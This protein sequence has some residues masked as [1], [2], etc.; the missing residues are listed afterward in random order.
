MY[1][2]KVISLSFLLLLPLIAHA[3]VDRQDWS[4]SKEKSI[5]LSESGNFKKSPDHYQS[6]EI[7]IDRFSSKLQEKS[8]EIEVPDPDGNFQTFVINPS[9]V[10]APEVAHLYTIKT[11][12]GYAKANPSIKIACDISQNGFNAAIFAVGKTYFVTPTNNVK[13]SKHISYYMSDLQVTKPGCHVQEIQ[14][15]IDKEVNKIWR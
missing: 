10:N 4:K 6:Y 8:Q 11:F 3:Q 7:S 2:L 13:P 15:F 9:F 12:T 1:L 5:S 14:S